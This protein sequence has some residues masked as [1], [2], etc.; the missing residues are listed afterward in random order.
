MA[1]DYFDMKLAVTPQT[2][3]PIPGAEAQVFAME[4]TTFANPLPITD[5]QGIPMAKLVASPTGVYPP[6]KVPSGETQVFAVSGAAI[7]PLTSLYGHLLDLIPN[8]TG[9]A[10]QLTIVTQSGA[11]VLAPAAMTPIPDATLGDE[12]QVLAIVDG[13]WA[14]TD[15]TGGSG[16][17]IGGILDG[18]AP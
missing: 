6:F 14:I 8:P 10:D 13:V 11:F 1:D 12:G 7:T 5:L 18:G 4:D 9:Q 17:T 16:G 15:P 2:L 3:V